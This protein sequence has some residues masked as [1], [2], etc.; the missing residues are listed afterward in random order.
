MSEVISCD[1]VVC[2]GVGYIHKKTMLEL[3]WAAVWLV[4]RKSGHTHMSFRCWLQSSLFACQFLCVPN[5][6]CLRSTESIFKAIKTTLG[7]WSGAGVWQGCG[8][9]GMGHHGCRSARPRCCLCKDVC[10]CVCV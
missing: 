6:D 3:C 8:L 9:V 7:G 1:V 4:T 10:V 2:V 5:T